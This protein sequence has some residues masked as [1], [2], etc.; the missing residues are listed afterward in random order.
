MRSPQNT[1][2]GKN[3]KIILGITI[4]VVMVAVA[5]GSLELTNKTHFFGS[6]KV[7]DEK[8]KTTSTAPTAQKDFTGGDDRHPSTNTSKGEGTVSDTQG[9][10]TNIPP[11]NQWTSS[12]NGVITVYSPGNSALVTNGSSLSGKAN[13]AKV[14]FRLI[15]DVSG[16]IAQGELSVVNGSFSGTFNFSTTATNGRLDVFNTQPDGVEFNNTEVPIRFK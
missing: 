5:I 1:N 15:D 14:S 13:S 8:T 16:V 10:V 11:S 4:A 3:K 12:P 2:R 9:N 7:I 6:D